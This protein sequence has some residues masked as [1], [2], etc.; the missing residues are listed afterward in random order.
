MGLRSR[1]RARML[2]PAITAH[3]RGD[4][5]YVHRMPNIDA[6]SVSA[7]I[8]R[9]EALGWRLESQEQT[10]IGGIAGGRGNGTRQL[11]LTLTFR[12]SS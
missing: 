2:Q 9:I 4:G 7:W 3:E 12:R 5:V 8:N 10:R 6:A 11:R 1:L